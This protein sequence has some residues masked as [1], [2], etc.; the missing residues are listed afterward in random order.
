MKQVIKVKVLTGGCEP[1]F[2]EKGDWIDL[3]AAEDIQID[4]PYANALHKSRS[5]RIRNVVNQKKL[6]PLGVAMKLPDGMEAIVAPRS[7]TAKNFNIMEANSIGIIDNSYC[8]PDDQWFFPAIAIDSAVI[9]K[10]D[11]I[12]Q[13]KIQPS[14]RATR[15]QKIRWLLSNGVEL[16]FVDTLTGSNR[17][18]NG[19][20]GVR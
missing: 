15:K 12:C 3:R 9:H 16:E 1:T 11:R 13:F 18:G 19:S 6:I 2:N 20:T 10:G 4:G 17:G 14:Q 7:S 8:G 5:E